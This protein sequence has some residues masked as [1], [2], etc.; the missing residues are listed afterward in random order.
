MAKVKFFGYGANRN[1]KR[2]QDIFGHEPDGG[3]SAILSN[4]ILAVQTLDQIP[5]EPRRILE[6][7]WGEKFRSYTV[8]DGK[9]E[10]VGTI[11]EI[12]ENDLR[13][14][15]RWEYIGDWRELKEVTVKTADGT[16]VRALT[17]RAPE[18]SLTKETV[19]G[20][21]YEDNLN[22]NGMKPN[23][24]GEDEK[25]EFRLDKLRKELGLLML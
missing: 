21:N 18:G 13:E 16:E 25:D 19:D 8:K 1:K 10:V 20:L 4:S 3:I 23:T 7:V 17:D 6:K 15:E 22:K 9:G 14:L 2:L 24:D 5:E 11:W 12:D